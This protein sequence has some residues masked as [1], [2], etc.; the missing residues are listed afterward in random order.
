MDG[1]DVWGIYLGIENSVDMGRLYAWFP[2]V[3]IY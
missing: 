2:K 1:P 3:G